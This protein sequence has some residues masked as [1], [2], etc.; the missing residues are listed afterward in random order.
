MFEWIS[1]VTLQL[2]V[3]IFCF[4]AGLGLL[5]SGLRLF[6]EAMQVMTNRWLRIIYNNMNEG[7]MK[8]ALAGALTSFFIQSG[9]SSSFMALS[10]SGSG[11]FSINQLTGWL[12]GSSLGTLPTVGLFFLDFFTYGLPLLGFGL[13]SLTHNQNKLWFCK[14]LFSIGIILLGY[15]LFH[16]G[17]QQTIMGQNPATVIRFVFLWVLDPFWSSDGML[18]VYTLALSLLIRSRVALVAL[19]MS[20]VSGGS[21]TLPSALLMILGVNIGYIIGIAFY[22]RKTSRTSKRAI[23]IYTVTLSCLSLLSYTLLKDY[24]HVFIK[25]QSVL[26]P[27]IS[28]AIFYISYNII[29]VILSLLLGFPLMGLSKKIIP[30]PKVK[31]NQKLKFPTGVRFLSPSLA[32]EQ[33]HQEVKKMSA[34]LTSLIELT[35][36]KKIIEPEAQRIIKYE[37]ITDNIETELSDFTKSI[38][39]TAL[40]R[41]Q[42]D[43]VMGL[44]RISEELE[45]LANHCKSLLL[46]RNQLDGE[47]ET[48]PELWALYQKV[49]LQFEKVF[50]YFTK[51]PLDQGEPVELLKEFA[52]ARVFV[53][54]FN[55]RNQELGLKILKHIGEMERANQEIWNQLYKLE[56]HQ[57][58]TL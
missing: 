10:F 26:S 54:S 2:L 58:G 50:S 32:I 45:D 38:F 25:D 44:L 35:M 14:L 9:T 57:Y 22:A 33:T 39:E 12:L 52:V 5:T 49:Q 29:F 40:T 30:N 15:H 37:S 20:F 48:P 1:G 6:S 13:F 51:T 8:A 11:L 41:R 27:M 53:G 17:F 24:S 36:S 21:L 4:I 7:L 31:E 55:E 56:S 43:E 46:L 47:K 19:V 42:V 34:M 16:L 18:F 3:I 28:V 23:F